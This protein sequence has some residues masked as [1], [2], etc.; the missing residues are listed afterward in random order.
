MRKVL[1]GLLTVILV[2]LALYVWPTP[3]RRWD[4]DR[5]QFREN[6]FTGTVEGRGIGSESITEWRDLE[7]RP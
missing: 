4:R 3:Y 1:V 7:E 6:R 2:L 5:M